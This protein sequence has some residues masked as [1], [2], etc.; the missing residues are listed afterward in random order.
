M[1]K[2][3]QEVV[4]LFHS[5]RYTIARVDVVGSLRHALN[6]FRGNHIGNIGLSG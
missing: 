2:L 3:Q 6:F 5:V 1:T 4:L